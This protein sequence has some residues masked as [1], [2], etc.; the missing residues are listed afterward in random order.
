MP[1]N[2]LL[3]RLRRWDGLSAAARLQVRP[4]AGRYLPELPMKNFYFRKTN[5]PEL[6]LYSQ[7]QQTEILK[8]I[9]PHWLEVVIFYTGIILTMWLGKVVGLIVF[10][11]TSNYW[12]AAIA[13]GSAVAAFYFFYEFILLN[14]FTRQRVL[15]KL[16]N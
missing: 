8:S 11:N 15:A 16:G 14:F 1:N 13:S 2:R 9:E 4:K 10:S 7:S 12:L 3:S 6:S 5:I